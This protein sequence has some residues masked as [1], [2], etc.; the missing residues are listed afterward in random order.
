M[1]FNRNDVNDLRDSAIDKND[2][3]DHVTELD[4]AIELT[5]R[6]NDPLSIR[7]DARKFPN[8]S[9]HMKSVDFDFDVTGEN[10]KVALGRFL[11]TLV[12]V[13]PELANQK[14]DLVMRFPNEK[15]DDGN[16]AVT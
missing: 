15:V 3:E 10:I 16:N 12:E 9:Y 1:G 5:T 13:R 7:I 11:D 4:G 8:G 6:W 2:P 14:R